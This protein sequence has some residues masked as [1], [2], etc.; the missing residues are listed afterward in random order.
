MIGVLGSSGV[1]MNKNDRALPERR[2]RQRSPRV[3]ADP[4]TNDKLTF[5]G[6]EAESGRVPL[7]V[8]GEDCG[9][10]ND[11]RLQRQVLAVDAYRAGDGELRAGRDEL[12]NRK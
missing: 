1:K 11:E 10:R 9:G 3:V 4:E 8:E 12:Y 7:S 5:L 2:R 6:V